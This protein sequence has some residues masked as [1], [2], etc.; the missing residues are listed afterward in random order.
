M[1]KSKLSR[2][3]IRKL[4]NDMLR[5]DADFESFC[6]DHYPEVQIRFGLGMERTEKINLLLQLEDDLAKMAEHIDVRRRSANHIAVTTKSA[7]PW[8]VKTAKLLLIVSAAVL[9]LGGFLG[10]RLWKKFTHKQS[11]IS[12][13]AISNHIPA[14]PV[15]LSVKPPL[16]NTATNQLPHTPQDVPMVNIGSNNDIQAGAGAKVFSGASVKNTLPIKL[17]PVSIQ[18]GSGNRITAGE[19]SMVQTGIE[20][21][22]P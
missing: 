17:P 1:L 16:G 21:R 3:S 5:T 13:S 12:S 8:S 9:G 22:Q 15:D 20:V 2:E 14:P 18:I 10:G 19:G 4:L 6:I 7:S 11:T